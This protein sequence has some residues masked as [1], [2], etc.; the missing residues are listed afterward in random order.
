M[1]CSTTI[2]ISPYMTD[3]QDHDI[4]AMQKFHW[5]IRDFSSLLGF[6]PPSK[7][8]QIQ[9][10]LNPEGQESVPVYP[11]PASQSL[12]YLGRIDYTVLAILWACLLHLHNLEAYILPH[13]SFNQS[14][15]ISPPKGQALYLL[16]FTYQKRNL[17]LFFYFLM[18]FIFSI[19]AVYSVLS[20]SYCTAK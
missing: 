16:S 2:C 7:S 1:V 3:T 4:S 10:K 13:A 20:I 18:I 8:S 19:I 5:F 15:F 6:V 11:L 17:Y 12:H 14:T 9:C